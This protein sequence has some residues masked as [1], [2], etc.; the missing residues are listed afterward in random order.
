MA[1]P[2]LSSRSVAEGRPFDQLEPPLRAQTLSILKSLTFVN[3]TPVQAAVIGLLGK[4]K[5]VSVEA[6]TG[7]GENARVRVTDD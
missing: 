1:P 3:S 4:N 7:S 5:D 6:C 2:P